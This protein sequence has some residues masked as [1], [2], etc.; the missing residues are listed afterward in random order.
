MA[1]ETPTIAQHDD[2]LPRK[3]TKPEGFS[4][5][6]LLV[7]ISILSMLMAILVPALGKA[8]GRARALLGMSNQAQIVGAVNCYAN[9]H[10]ERY[11][12][13][14]ATLGEGDAWGWQ[15][16]TMLTGYFKRSP[17]CHRSVGAYL[18]G[19]LD[20]ARVA[21]CPSAPKDY[22]YLQDS[23]NAGDDWDNPDTRPVPDPVFGTYCFYWNYVGYLEEQ[24]DMFVGPKGPAG[25]G[26]Q[27]SVLVSDYFGYGHWRSPHS[28]GSC[29]M[30]PRGG[31]TDGTDVSSAYWSQPDSGAGLESLA[32]ELHAAY[33]DGHVAKY[34]PSD[35]VPMRVSLSSDGGTPYP[36]GVGPGVFY[37]PR[38]GLQ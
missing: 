5:I 22:K 25:G 10:D 2:N 8:R 28:F 26:A 18:V 6:E 16:P 12:E 35:V 37:L 27:S 32:V 17:G 9:E 4:L 13:S 15:E 34:R 30:L 1:V 3:A 19:Y 14:T 38:D 23:W 7:A 31:I 20:E 36:V 24:R 11:P 29:E 21:F 33:L